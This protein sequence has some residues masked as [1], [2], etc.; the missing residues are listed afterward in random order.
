MSSNIPTRDVLKED[1]GWEV[2]VETV[3]LPSQGLTYDPDS[4]LYNR[5]SLDIKAMTAKEEDILTSQALIKRGETVSELVK[6]CLS[7]KTIN[8]D[9]MLLGDRNALMVSVR[10]TGYGTQYKSAVT[11]K[12]CSHVNNRTIDL[13][14][15]PISFLELKPVKKGINAFEYVLPVTKKKVIFK[16]LSV[17]DER[18]ISQ[19]K[20]KMA[21]HFSSIVENNV[22]A[23]LEQCITA[24]D[25][26]TDKNKIRH[27]VQYMPAFD[28]KSLRNYMKDN[29]P[30]IKME[31]NLVCDE[32]SGAST[33]LV[34]MSSE[35]FWPSE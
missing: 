32:C 33:V 26:I 21:K 16:F 35:F 9:D 24:I 27:F 7:D 5:K 8:V 13:G 28:S 3:P 17:R 11:C 30:G 19:T 14:N 34:P 20:E 22:T 31:Y 23:N 4:S 15:L 10:I 1:F 6:S 29:E 12:H 2:P 18:E 25:G